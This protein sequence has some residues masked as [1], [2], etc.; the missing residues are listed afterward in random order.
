MNSKRVLLFLTSHGSLGETGKAT[1]FHYSEMA[2]PYRLFEEAG[3]E[4]LFGS[5]V[6][7]EPPSDPGSADPENESVFKFY[8]SERALNALKHSRSLQEILDIGTEFFDA[9]YLCGGH[10][11]M[12]DFPYNRQLSQ[13]LS[14]MFSQGKVV[15]AVCH[16]VAGLLGVDEGSD[17]PIV[18]EKRLTSF[19]NAEEDSV[20]TISAVPFL[21]ESALISAGA[22]FQCSP[23]A[24]P[25]VVQDGFLITGQNPS[26]AEGVAKAM[27]N[28]LNDN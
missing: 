19:S 24:E 6:G 28:A 4:V 15:G 21:L 5:V 17:Q 23:P 3:F 25:C 16:G 12:W 8:S 27:V 26:S 7:G 22:H 10:G 13:V 18:F 14:T 2:V 11:A 20:G 9:I 1:G